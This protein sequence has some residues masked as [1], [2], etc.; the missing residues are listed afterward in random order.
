MWETVYVLTGIALGVAF[1]NSV[2][3]AVLNIDI[4][5]VKKHVFNKSD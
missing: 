5:E 3:I 2:K 4:K 1:Q